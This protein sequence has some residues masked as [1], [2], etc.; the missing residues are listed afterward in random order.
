MRVM[1][2]VCR[3][4][5][6]I[7]RQRA[8]LR[9]QRCQR[10][11]KRLGAGVHPPGITRSLRPTRARPRSRGGCVFTGAGVAAGGVTLGGWGGEAGGAAGGVAASGGEVGGGGGG[12][13]SGARPPLD[14]TA[15]ITVGAFTRPKRTIPG[16]GV[17]VWAIACSTSLFD[18]A[19]LSDSASAAIP[20]TIGA[21]DDVPQNSMYSAPGQGAVLQPGAAT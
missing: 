1:R 13:G 6:A 10:K 11:T 5:R 3:L 17:A 9:A 19:G 18:A 2:Y 20:D 15:L 7:V 4:A 12:G 8:P 14:E 21:A 16:S